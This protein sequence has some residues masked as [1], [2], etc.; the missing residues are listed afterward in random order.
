MGTRHLT[1]IVVD[2]QYK[3]AQYGQWDGYP[4][5]AGKTIR[6]ALQ[7]ALSDDFEDFV[8]KVRATR[9]ISDQEVQDRFDNTGIEAFRTQ[10]PQLSRDMGYKIV[11]HI[12]N[13]PPGVEVNHYLSFASDSLFCEYA[14]IID[15]DNNTLEV[16]KGFNTEPV[17]TTE[18]FYTAEPNSG[19]Y[20]PVK[21]WK[22]FALNELPNEKDFLAQLPEGEDEESSEPSSPTP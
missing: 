9:E 15:L 14:Y 2:G 19:G 11:D 1:A 7:R 3:V 8:E 16:Y 13:Q 5:A 18:R 12:L 4:T 20:Y 17:D 21:L 22:V 6:N 10:Y